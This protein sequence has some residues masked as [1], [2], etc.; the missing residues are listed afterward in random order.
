MKNLKVLTFVS[1]SGLSLY[2]CPLVTFFFTKG[3]LETQLAFATIIAT[4]KAVRTQGA[5][6]PQLHLV[7][8]QTVRVVCGFDSLTKTSIAQSC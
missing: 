6:H 8:N 2:L 4:A 5:R 3:A 1:F 7:N